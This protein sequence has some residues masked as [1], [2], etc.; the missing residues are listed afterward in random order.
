MFR[1]LAVRTSTSRDWPECFSCRSTLTWSKRWSWLKSQ[2]TVNGFTVINIFS[3]LNFLHA[4]LLHSRKRKEFIYTEL[5]TPCSS[6]RGTSWRRRRRRWPATP[7]RNRK[8]RT[9][10]IQVNIVNLL[11]YQRC[12]NRLSMAILRYSSPC[13]SL[14]PKVCGFWKLSRKQGHGASDSAASSWPG[15]SLIRGIYLGE[16]RFCSKLFGKVR[17]YSWC[18][19]SIP[20]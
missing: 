8:W 16:T 17:L 5:E 7:A 2:G 19:D 3:S 11:G 4:W 20:C 15:W 12:E 14:T 10:P 1:T 9:Q 18:E 6:S 13:G